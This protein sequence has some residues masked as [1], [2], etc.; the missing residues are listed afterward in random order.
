MEGP[1]LPREILLRAAHRR[2]MLLAERHHPLVFDEHLL[3]GGRDPEDALAQ[4]ARNAAEGLDAISQKL[5]DECA[6][7][8]SPELLQ[9][10][11]AN[12]LAQAVHSSNTRGRQ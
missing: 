8:A 1:E 2:E 10:P 6:K 7:I 4:N 5:F 3:A 11:V 12:Q 9:H